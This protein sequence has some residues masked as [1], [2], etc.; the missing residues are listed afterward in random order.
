M[1]TDKIDNHYFQQLS[2]LMDGDLAPDQA[3]FLL[4][5]RHADLVNIAGKRSS[6]AYLNHQLCAIEGV[7]EGAFFLPDEADQSADGITRPGCYLLGSRNN[8]PRNR[9]NRAEPSNRPR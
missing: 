5:G 4:H 1:T 6:L 8:Q 7:Q 3:R 9:N 2:A